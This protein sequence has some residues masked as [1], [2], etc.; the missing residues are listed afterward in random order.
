MD[1]LLLALLLLAVALQMMTC[2][3]IW[4]GTQQ[5]MTMHEVSWAKMYK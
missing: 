5:Q 4:T 3:G 2:Q 1:I